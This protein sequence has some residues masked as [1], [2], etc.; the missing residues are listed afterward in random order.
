MKLRERLDRARKMEPAVSKSEASARN[1]REVIERIEGKIQALEAHERRFPARRAEWQAA[2]KLRGQAKRGA[3]S[4]ALRR[5]IASPF[6]RS[7]LEFS[8]VTLCADE[9]S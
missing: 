2:S 8:T 7:M 1:L 9:P 3:P 5:T 6:K 4:V